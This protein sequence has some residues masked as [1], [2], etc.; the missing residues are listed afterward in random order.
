MELPHYTHTNTL[1]QMI[2]L[3]QDPTGEDIFSPTA[4]SGSGGGN[5]RS[6][7]KVNGGSGESKVKEKVALLE[8]QIQELELELRDC[9]V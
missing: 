9:Q 2:Y 1:L 4:S 5:P 8:K 7:A 3:Y 6:G